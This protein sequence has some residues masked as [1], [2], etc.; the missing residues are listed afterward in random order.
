MFK[1]TRT[2]VKSEISNFIYYMS[3]SINL[4]NSKVNELKRNKS[5]L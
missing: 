2:L 3:I 1:E 4:K 5:M